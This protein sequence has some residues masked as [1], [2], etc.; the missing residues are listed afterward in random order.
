MSNAI[1]EIKSEL[2]SDKEKSL[3]AQELFEREKARIAKLAGTEVAQNLSYEDVTEQERHQQEI[4]EIPGVARTSIPFE[5]GVSG[6]YSSVMKTETGIFGTVEDF[7]SHGVGAAIL[8]KLGHTPA[9]DEGNLQAHPAEYIQRLD[10]RMA[11][12]LKG[13]SIV[14]PGA[15]EIINQ[16]DRK[17]I[18]IAKKGAMMLLLDGATGKIIEIGQDLKLPV[19]MGMQKDIKAEAYAFKPGDMFFAGT[20]GVYELA[21]NLKDGAQAQKARFYQMI[22]AAVKEHKGKPIQEISDAILEQVE[23]AGRTDD[24]TLIAIQL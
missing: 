19:G 5:D 13:R 9:E 3:G 4:P 14:S 18:H 15:F 8:R 2:S 10:R 7:A 23:Q 17:E 12:N 21:D 1:E 20:D 11:K 24:V 22:E 16:P 6:D